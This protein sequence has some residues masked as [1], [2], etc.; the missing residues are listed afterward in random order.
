MTDFRVMFPDMDSDVIEAVLRANNGAVDATID[1]LLAMSADMESENSMT[2]TSRPPSYPQNPPSYQQA[3]QDDEGD[4][5]NLGQDEEKKAPEGDHSLD[6]LDN[7]PDTRSGSNVGHAYSHPKRQEAEQSIPTSCSPPSSSSGR[8]IV[9]TQQMLQEKY[10][11]NLRLREEARMNPEQ[12]AARAQYL[13]DERLALMM[14]NEEFIAELRSDRDFMSALAE[15]DEYDGASGYDPSYVSGAVGGKKPPG[16]KGRSL[17][18]DE[19]MF[20]EKL[21]NMSK[22]SKRKFTQLANMF[23]RRKGAKELLGHAPAPSND[24]LLLNAEPLIN[25]EFD[26][27]EEEEE[28][29]H[30][31]KK[32]PTKGKYT[33][34]S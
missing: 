21:K 24:N 31:Q 6:P 20:R 1:H 27:S 16:A 15:E 17:M 28:R 22:S 33:S 14:Q 34:F 10:E 12:A 30:Q 19:T 9:P 11:E 4:L 18:M 7:L 2:G 25:Q 26:E 3:T 8:S 13:E 23:S 32:T 5:I 29:Q